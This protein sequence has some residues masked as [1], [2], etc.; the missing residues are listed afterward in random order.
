MQMAAKTGAP[1]FAG[2]TLRGPLPLQSV[3]RW[4]LEHAL[5]EPCDAAQDVLD[6]YKD[7]NRTV[8]LGLHESLLE[9]VPD[10][11]GARRDPDAATVLCQEFGLELAQARAYRRL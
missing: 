11:A 6:L 3:D 9:L 2:V 1:T 7:K 10:V 5:G 4:V 8:H